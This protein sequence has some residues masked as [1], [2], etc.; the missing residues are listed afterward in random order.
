MSG[1]LI[2]EDWFQQMGRPSTFMQRLHYQY[3]GAR[4]F[5]G[6]ERLAPIDIVD[7]LN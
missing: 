6:F 1:V 2:A 5:D 7:K 3:I 4:M